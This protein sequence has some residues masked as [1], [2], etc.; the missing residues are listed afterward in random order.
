[1]HRD[2]PGRVDRR[3]VFLIP[4]YGRTL[5]GTTDTD[6]AGDPARVT[7]DEEDIDYLLAQARRALGPASWSRSDVICAFAG[8]RTLPASDDSSPSAVSREWRLDE[9]AEG[10]LVSVGGK[11]TSARADAAQPF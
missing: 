4:W 5:L 6:Y 10:L 2:R 8:V 1:M 3:I 7:V 9:T 11:Y